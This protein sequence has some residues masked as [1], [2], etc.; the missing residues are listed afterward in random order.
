MK[1][2]RFVTDND[3]AVQAG[4]MTERG[5]EVIQGNMFGDW[6]FTGQI[7]D[8]STAKL[9]A[10]LVPRHIVGIGKNFVTEGMPVPEAPA[11][12]IWFFKPTT[13][14]IGPDAAIVLP[15]PSYEA[16]FESELA[17]IIGKEGKNVTVDDAKDYIFGYTIANDLADSTYFH[18]EG[19]WTMGKS[20]DT[21]CPLGPHIETDLQLDQVRIKS[22]LNGQ[23]AQDSSLALM[24]TSIAQQIAN[25]SSFM[26]IQ[27]GDVIL[28]GTPAGADML[29]ANDMIECEITGIGVLRNTVVNAD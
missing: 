16:K 25:V 22:Y 28:T 10:P 23:L 18:S 13:G 9:L 14:V 19:H 2:I 3:S 7:V 29:H 8:P 17:V 1:F 6:S 21:F 27:P 12:P 5:Y 4:V 26:T 11:I 24:I 15:A 20:F